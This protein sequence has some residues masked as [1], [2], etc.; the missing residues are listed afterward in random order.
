MID[1]RT[2]LRHG[3]LLAGI[4]VLASCA[5]DD[6]SDASEFRD[7]R[8]VVPEVLT[9]PQA[10]KLIERVRGVR[11]TSPVNAVFVPG[12]SYDSLVSALEAQF[13]STSEGPSWSLS[14]TTM[15]AL[16]MVD[17]FGRWESASKAFDEASVLG[18]YLPLN[19]T[20][21]ILSNA[22]DDPLE[23]RHVLLHELAHALQD[24]MY[25]LDALVDR[26]KE[27]D[28]YDAVLALVEGEADYIATAIE[29]GNPPA[30]LLSRAYG[31]TLPSM[32]SL[33]ASLESM[34]SNLGV[35]LS[36]SLPGYF[37]YVH[38]PAWVAFQ[39]AEAGWPR[40][41]SL[42]RKLPNS[43]QAILVPGVI[44]PVVDWDPIAGPPVSP[45][46]SAVQTGRLGPV[47]LAA[48]VLGKTAGG[49]DFLST[50][51]NF[52]RGDRF[53]VFRSQEGLGVVWKLDFSTWMDAEGFSRAFW[54][55]RKA[56]R[57]AAGLVDSQVAGMGAHLASDATGSRSLRI[58]MWTSGATLGIAE[59]F[60]LAE[61]DSLLAAIL[62]QETGGP[63]SGRSISP[64]S[65]RG[66]TGGTWLPP[67]SWIP[68]PRV[69]GAPR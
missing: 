20:L 36:M 15:V 33:V 56:R 39:R 12:G 58:R 40:V 38:G 21:Y 60:S 50:G 29:T 44:A 55:S 46:W 69:P 41:D 10:Q 63:F 6:G 19:K 49:T 59:G 67:R 1:R 26:A 13:G 28:E 9:V 27:V 32:D 31:A 45:R 7:E 64:G 35:P 3:T 30:S 66:F 22:D 11:F 61:S 65:T 68:H 48:L 57:D 53:W 54:T 34:W 52:W 16:G 23:K 17:S 14:E 8:M 47:R 18:F 2:K 25:G 4:L 5:V 62:P 24:Q 42:F 43:T 37:P 51:L